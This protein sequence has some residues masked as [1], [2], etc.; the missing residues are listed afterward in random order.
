M[1]IL[2]IV[3]LALLSITL[4]SMGLYGF[5]KYLVRCTSLVLINLGITGVIYCVFCLSYILIGA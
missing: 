2:I 1:T 5:S 4:M 3:F